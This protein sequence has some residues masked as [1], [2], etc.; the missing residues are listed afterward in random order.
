METKQ[1]CRMPMAATVT[2]GRPVTKD[3]CVSTTTGARDRWELSAT[4]L[5]TSSAAWAAKENGL[6]QRR[7][8]MST[9]N[10]K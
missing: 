8:V 5:L 4:V 2:T 3:T 7:L 1:T 6:F 9:V 10:E